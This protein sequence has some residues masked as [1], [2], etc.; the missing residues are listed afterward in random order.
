MPVY[1]NG[2][3]DAYGGAAAGSNKVGA[4]LSIT[5]YDQANTN[6][7]SFDMVGGSLNLKQ[8]ASVVVNNGYYQNAG[9]L[10]SDNTT[11]ALGATDSGGKGYTGDINIAGGS[12]TVDT[13][14]DS[15]ASLIFAAGTVEFNGTL[16][17][18][19]MLTGGN[20]TTQYDQL[21]CESAKMTLGPNSA[22]N[23]GTTGSNP[24]GLG[25]GNRWYV[26]TYGSI[27]G[28][29]PKWGQY[30]VPPTM[31]APS[32]GNNNVLVSN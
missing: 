28:Q 11:C 26:M 27:T 4:T 5:G 9:S 16:N 13:V 1:N 12:V 21:T 18:N 17:V 24:N 31:S 29:N 25:T 8:S 22:L 32:V 23:L 14:A 6:N 19:G 10:T 7:V 3:F 20:N 15:Y 2:E 30:K